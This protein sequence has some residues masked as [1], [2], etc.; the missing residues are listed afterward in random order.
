MLPNSGCRRARVRGQTTELLHQFALNVLQKFVRKWPP[1]IIG[2]RQQDVN[3]KHSYSVARAR[4]SSSLCLS[5][6]QRTFS[7][8]ARR[9]SVWLRPVNVEE[10]AVG[11]P[12]H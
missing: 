12:F 1:V 6:S 5:L 2:H 7:L 10:P 9:S 3:Q 8:S 4:A 11:H